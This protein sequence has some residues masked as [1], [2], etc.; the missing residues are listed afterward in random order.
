MSGKL[1]R[2]GWPPSRKPIHFPVLYLERVQ[3]RC[4][5]WDAARDRS[6]II[7]VESCNSRRQ[8][9]DGF[10]HI[11]ATKNKLSDGT[12]A[13]KSHQVKIDYASI[14]NCV[15]TLSGLIT[16]LIKSSNCLFNISWQNCRQLLNLLR[17]EVQINIHSKF[18]LSKICAS[19]VLKVSLVS[20]CEK[21]ASVKTMSTHNTFLIFSTS[22]SNRTNTSL[23]TKKHM[24]ILHKGM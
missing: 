10:G 21:K 4:V 17:W 19:L 9:L 22:R 20:V 2:S 23:H 18:A 14:I 13:Q 24:T 16:I 1:Q 3:I 12:V 11:E 8:F 7:K 5:E 15:N 6:Q